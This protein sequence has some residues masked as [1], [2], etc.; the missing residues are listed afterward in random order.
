MDVREE[1]AD[2]RTDF[3]GEHDRTASLNNGGGLRR[4]DVG[5]QVELAGRNAD[6]CDEDRSDESDHHDLQVGGAICGIEGRVHAAT[7]SP[8]TPGE[9]CLW[10]QYPYTKVEGA[11][12]GPFGAEETQKILK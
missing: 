2:D 4:H 1:L 5:A 12:A 9:Y 7:K 10:E 6:H 11:P 3:V 8:R